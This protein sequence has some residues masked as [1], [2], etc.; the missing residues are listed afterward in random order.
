MYNVSEL[1][2][3]CFI[4]EKNVYVVQFTRQLLQN[5]KYKLF[6]KLKAVFHPPALLQLILM[7]P[8]IVKSHTYKPILSPGHR[9][10]MGLLH[11]STSSLEEYAGSY[12][13]GSSRIIIGPWK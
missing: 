12:A 2:T 11:W 8:S 6:C 9:H 4:L 5:I 3:V 10:R 7:N 1:T 13:L